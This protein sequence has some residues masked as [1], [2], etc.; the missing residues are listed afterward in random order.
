[1]K[2][3][4]NT[5]SL[6][7]AIRYASRWRKEEGTY[8]AHHEVHAFLIPK[9]DFVEVLDEEIDAVRAYLGVDDLG[10]EKLMI[11]GTKYNPETET[12][13]DIIP[14]GMENVSIFDMTKPCP[15]ACAKDTKLRTK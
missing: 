5:L 2:E 4:E 15:N 9:I 8:N 14:D 12:Y 1:M 10:E 13:E 6:V 3:R 11:V 7:D